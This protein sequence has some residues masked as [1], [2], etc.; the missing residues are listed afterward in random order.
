MQKWEYLTARVSLGEI[1][2]INGRLIDCTIRK[3]TEEFLQERGNEGWELVGLG[4]YGGG[5]EILYFKRP[6]S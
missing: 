5:D 3:K 6:K 2:Y 1:S 4:I